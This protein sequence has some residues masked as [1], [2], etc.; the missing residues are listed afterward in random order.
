MSGNG[1]AYRLSKSRITVCALVVQVWLV[2]GAWGQGIS[3]DAAATARLKLNNLREGS[4]SNSTL[5][6]TFSES[7][8]NSYLALDLSRLY[9]GGVQSIEAQL[10]Q[11]RVVGTARIDFD[12]LKESSPQLLPPMAAY[13]LFG[14]HDVRVEGLLSGR[15]GVGQFTI[16]SALMDGVPLPQFLVEAV[17]NHY[18]HRRFPDKDL[19][20]PFGLPYSI[21]SLSVRSGQLR[22]AGPHASA[23]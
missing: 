8:V 23:Q 1:T 9:P 4:L 6:V 2:V 16:V 22:L 10:Q 3:A 18:L 13:L 14:T 11:D 12:R 7:E 5:T 17:A 19:N 21:D 15:A 20:S